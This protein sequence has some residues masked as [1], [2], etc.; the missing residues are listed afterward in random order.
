MKKLLAF[1][2]L[3]LALSATPAL[4]QQSVNLRNGAG[5][6]FLGVEAEFP[7]ARNAVL[8]AGVGTT[9]GGFSVVGGGKYFFQ[10]EQR[11]AGLYGA[12]RLGLY[13]GNGFAGFLGV[14]TAGYRFDLGKASVDLNRLYVDLEAG[15][16]FGAYG[17]GYLAGAGVGPAFGIGLG[18]R[19]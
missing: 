16:S 2:A 14:A 8:N 5:Y 9:F 19:F 6:G 13:A 18:Y 17:D 11:L 1:S 4:A 7:V 15:V 3:T 12:G 10:P